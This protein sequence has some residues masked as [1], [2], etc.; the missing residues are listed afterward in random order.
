MEKA[1]D[2]AM[3]IRKKAQTAKAER[4]EAGEP[5]SEDYQNTQNTE[6][7]LSSKIE[8]D[9][10]SKD[11]ELQEIKDRNKRE[12]IRQRMGLPSAESMEGLYLNEKEIKSESSRKYAPSK[13]IKENIVREKYIFDEKNKI[14]LE[15]KAC[16]IGDGQGADT[17]IFLSMGVNPKNIESVNYEGKE[18]DY[19]NNNFE[20]EVGLKGT[21]VEMKKGDA[22]SIESLKK[23][24]IE[25]KSQDIVTLMHVL[26]VPDI[27]GKIEEN[28]VKNLKMILKTDGELLVSQYKKKLTPEQARLFE[29][30]K[31]EKDDL[32]KKFGSDWRER[33][34][35][36]Y[37]K[38]WYPGMPYS[39]ISRI[40]S[41]E[42]LI[43][44]F[45]KDF[46]IRVDENDSEYILR[47]KRRD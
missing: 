45:E 25:E 10:L 17:R 18:V 12:E 21:G 14:N 40:R 33:F 39:E 1:R 6:K 47:M 26:E 9:K 20:E 8:Q 24:G 42:E 44:I 31:I 27:K 23:M 7:I 16:L 2:E 29:V 34:K 41:R 46:V 4:D 35:R 3:E 36:E 32:E 43:K 22:T 5:S 13:F 37:G 30:E 11:R 15:T 38:E 28:L 19:A